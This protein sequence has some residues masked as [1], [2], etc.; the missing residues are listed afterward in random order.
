MQNFFSHARYAFAAYDPNV[1]RTMTIGDWGEILFRG[2]GLVAEQMALWAE[3]YDP[4]FILAL[5]DNIYQWGIFSVDDPQ[6]DRKW[7]DVYHN[8]TSLE[9]LQWRLLHGNHD[10]G[11]DRGEEWYQVS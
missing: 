10:L 1:F 5:G 7:R 4:E 11:F 2:Q 3:D 9:N 6:L 8:Y